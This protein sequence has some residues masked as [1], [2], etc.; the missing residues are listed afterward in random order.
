MRFLSYMSF[1]LLLALASCKKDAVDGSSVKAFQSS[2]NDMSYSLTTL[3][4]TKFHEALYILKTFAVEGDTD[5]QKLEA[6]AKLINAKKVPEIF[7]LADEVARKNDIDWSSTA[8]PSLG[9]MNIFQNISAMEFDANDIKASSLDIL[10]KPIDID[11]VVGAKALRVIP[12]LLDNQGKEV[13][14]SNAGLETIMEVYSND[15]RLLTSK[16]LM[17][18]NNFN[19]FYLKL[20]SLPADKVVDSRIDIKVIVKTTNK[21]YQ[22]LKTGIEVNED[23]LAKPQI[24]VEPEIVEIEQNPNIEEKAPTEKPENVVNQFLTN[25]GN[26][27]LK[28]AFNISENPNWNSYEQFS[29]TNIGFGAVKN[30]SVKN[31]STI[32]H[33]SQSAE[34][35]A[36]YQVEDNDG[37]VMI[38]NTI[39]T[40]KATENGWKI[41][42]YRVNSSQKQ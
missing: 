9:E 2:I 37:N 22:F 27:N 13:V 34:V 29:D 39:Y 23:V 31:I 18:D 26:R 25:I 35:G 40:L 42:D 6:L 20:K 4:Q 1:A 32:S 8:P 28:K 38:L 11:E 16:N 5:L 33:N 7:T 41:S 3:E 24:V 19:G 10:V 14:F 12:K 15:E 17:T 36:E 30:I 21:T